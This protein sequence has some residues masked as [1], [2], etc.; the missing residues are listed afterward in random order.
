MGDYFLLGIE[1]VS[2]IPFTNFCGPNLMILSNTY[3]ICCCF[4]HTVA[5]KEF[6]FV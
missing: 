2:Y 4:T 6:G 1:D 5:Y 3:N